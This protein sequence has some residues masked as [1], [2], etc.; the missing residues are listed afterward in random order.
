MFYKEYGKGLSN[1]GNFLANKLQ[2]AMDNIDLQ[3]FLF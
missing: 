2:T 1:F 3:D